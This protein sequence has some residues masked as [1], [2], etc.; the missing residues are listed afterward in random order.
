MQTIQRPMAL[1]F[2]L[3]DGNADKEAE[4]LMPS[5][6]FCVHRG[7]FEEMVCVVKAFILLHSLCNQF[8]QK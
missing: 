8:P 1:E 3:G 5:P 4:K 2:S 6:N 7:L